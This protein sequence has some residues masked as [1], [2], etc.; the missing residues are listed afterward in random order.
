MKYNIDPANYEVVWKQLNLSYFFTT[1]WF[2][3]SYPEWDF[4]V[5]IDGSNWDIYLGNED[6]SRLGD[7]GLELVEDMDDFRKELHSAVDDAKVYFAELEKKELSGLSN[8]ELAEDFER[9]VRFM[10][11]LGKL[12]FLTEYFMYDKVEEKAKELG[13]DDEEHLTSSPFENVLTLELYERAK[14]AL[15]CGEDELKAHIAK[16]GFVPFNESRDSYDIDSLKKA[17]DEVDNPKEKIAELEK[18]DAEVMGKRKSHPFTDAVREM[19]ELK[20]L[21][22]LVI[23]KAI[24]GKHDLSKRYAAEI[25]K[26]LGVDVQQCHWE[27]LVAWLNGKDVAAVDRSKVVLGRFNGWN[28][29]VEEEA[30]EII[31]IFAD[32]GEKVSELKGTVACKG[33]H[34]G[35]AVVIP[36]D[37]TLD[38][39]KKLEEI[40]KGDIIVAVSTGPEMM[41]GIYRAGAIVTDEGG[42]CSHAAIVSRELGIPC[43]IGTKKGTQVFEDGDV[44]EVD[45]EEGIV[46]KVE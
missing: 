35:K 44:I 12:F 26:R 11:R 42:I 39:E 10:K 30:R 22:R 4:I 3:Q 6:R 24:F 31:D 29:L 14:L 21:L 7:V 8:A 46:R 33:K 16:W 20:F 25:G 9:L 40:K 34:K 45:A 2:E 37:P 28:A 17:I 19:Q 41:K 13:I 27:E 38:M 5:L 15:G 18:R 32:K 36:F 1:T 23:N 43:V